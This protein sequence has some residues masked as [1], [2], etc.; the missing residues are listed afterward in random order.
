MLFILGV[1][2]LTAGAH[3]SVIGEDDRRVPAAEDSHLESAVG[4][5][6]CTHTFDS[7]RRRSAGTATIVGSRSTLLTAAHVFEDEAGRQGPRVLFDPVRDCVFRQYDASG[8]LR[9]EIAIRRAEMGEFRHNAVV[10]NQDWAILE[11]AGLLPPSATFIPFASRTTAP[12]DLAGLS[13]RMIAFHAD[14]DRARRMPLL[15]EG[16]LFRIDYGG[17]TRLAHTADTGRMS[18]GAAIVHRTPDGQ[19]IVVG[20]NRSSAN[21]GDF[22]LAVP[23]TAELTEALRS[24]AYG[25]VPIREHR[26][27]GKRYGK[28]AT[29][30][31]TA[32]AVARRPTGPR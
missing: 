27:A 3:S 7:G 25:Q 8:V 30:A 23:L 21:F 29:A 28:A 11:T 16:E 9:F 14:V 17:F 20:V 10:P 13:M 24:F 15:S 19:S 1:L 12:G 22:N 18:S 6:F 2:L 5:I 4:L 26:L 32:L 31:A